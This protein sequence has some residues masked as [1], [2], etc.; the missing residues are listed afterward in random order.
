MD[1]DQ[2][3]HCVEIVEVAT[4]R[5]M[6]AIDDTDIEG[7]MEALADGE[8]RLWALFNEMP[9]PVNEIASI[10]FQEEMKRYRKDRANQAR[11]ALFGKD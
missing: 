4:S 10:A 11:L 2:F 8:A 1:G 5:A 6:A 9:Q 7:A 3:E